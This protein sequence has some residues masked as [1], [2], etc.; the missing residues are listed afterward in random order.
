MNAFIFSKRATCCFLL[1]VSS[2]LIARASNGIAGPGWQCAVS[3][4]SFS[5][6]SSG[7][8]P[9][10]SAQAAAPAATFTPAS[11]GNFWNNGGTLAPT[12][13]TPEIQALATGLDNDPV[14]IF[15]YVHNQIAFQPYYGSNK[16]AQVTYLD[17]AGNDVDQ[18]SLLI[19]L[20]SQV[21]GCTSTLYVY[22]V[23]AMPDSPVDPSNPSDPLNNENLSNW[24]GVPSAA[25]PYVLG[26]N[27]VP[28]N[29]RGVSHGNYAVWTFDHVWVR[30]TINGQ[31]YDLDPSYKQYTNYNP[32]DFKTASGYV[33][34]TLLSNAEAGSNFS[35]DNTNYVQ[36]MS[37]ANVESQLG[38]CAFNLQNYIKGNLP[39]ANYE[40]AQILGGGHINSQPITALAQ[41][42]P[43][44]LFSPSVM[45]TFSSLPS[46][47]SSQYTSTG[48]SYNFRAAFEVNIDSGAIDETFYTDNLQGKRL[49]VTFDSGSTPQQ[50]Q[51]WWS[52]TQVVEETGGT[53]MTAGVTET[54]TDPSGFSQS[55]PLTGNPSIVYQRTGNYDLTYSFFP[56]PYSNGQI[57]E[58]TRQIQNYLASGHADSSRQVLTETLHSL[59]LKWIRRVALT[60]QMT[61]RA[62]YTVANGN[63]QYAPFAQLDHI[64]GRTGQ[65][66]GFFVDMPGVFFTY[67]DTASDSNGNSVGQ[68]GPTARNAYY[69]ALFLSSAM[70]HG[71]IEQTTNSTAL[72]AIKCLALANDQGQQIYRATQSNW[73]TG[74]NVQSKL[75]TSNGQSTYSGELST[76]G[77][78]IGTYDDIIL[79][80]QN[81]QTSVNPGQSGSQW[82]G[83]GYADFGTRTINGLQENFG[84]LIIAGNWGSSSGGYES[85]PT[86]LS[87]VGDDTTIQ[88]DT[89]V[90][91]TGTP[92]ATNSPV[93]T[94]ISSD[95]TSAEPV[96]LLTGAYTM[97]HTDLTLGEQGSPRGLNFTRYY[98]GLRNFTP[99]PLGNGWRHSCQG[100]ITL[101]SELDNAFGLTQPTDAVQTIV[102]AIVVADFVNSPTP[103]EMLVGALAANWTVNCMT[104]NAANVQIGN[105]VSTYI[106][107]PNGT[108]TWN[109]PPGS[110]TDLT[111]ASGSFALQP[112]LGG[113]IVFDSQNRISTWTDV[114]GNQEIYFYD[115]NGNLQTVTDHFGRTL[116]FSY[117]QNGSAYLLQNVVDSTGR[118]V[119]FT[120]TAGTSTGVNSPSNLTGITDPQNY[121]TTLVYDGRNR[122]TDW[123]DSSSNDITHND[124]DVLDRVSQ[125]LSQ[126]LTA[127]TWLFH[128]SP[129]MTLQIDPQGD[130]TTNLFDY[131]NRNIGTIDALENASSLSYDGQNHVVSTVDA[132]NRKTSYVYDAN[133]NLVT[134]TDNNNNTTYCYYNST[135]PF[136][137]SQVKDANGFSTFYGY[138]NS[139]D[140][141]QHH[142]TSIT[143]AGGRELQYYFKANGLLD[144]VVDSASK[145][146]SYA[147]YDA[148]GN[149]TNITRADGTKTSA[150]Y[151]ARGDLLSSTD[152]LNNTTYYS[153]DNRRLMLTR[154]DANLNTTT[155]TYDSNG[156]PAT[157]TDRNNNTTTYVYDNLGHELSAQSPATGNIF[158]TYDNRGWLT[159]VTDGLGNVTTYGYD[160]TGRRTSVTNP[161]SIT[162]SQ[163]AY[164]PAGRVHVQTDGL[165][166]E[167]V[168][169]YDTV[170]YLAS[171]TDPL[172]HIT[173]FFY[174]GT[175]RKSKLINKNNQP[176]QFGYSTTDGLP[177]TFTYPSGRQSL[178]TARDAHGL[179]M[180]L[181][182]PSGNT[183]NLTYDAMSRISTSADG[184]GGIGWTY[185]NEGNP[186]DIK[187]TL[188]NN[189]NTTDI[190]RVYDNLG[191]VTSCTDTQL[192]TVGYS[193]DNEGNLATITYPGG[194][195]VTY[196]YDG[197]NRLTTVKDWSGR[198]TKYTYDSAGRLQTVLR[199]NNTQQTVTFDAASRLTGSTEQLLNSNGN[200]TLWQAAYGYDNA[201]HLTSFAPLPA[202]QTQAP[203]AVALTYNNDNELSTY[204]GTNVNYDLDGN[205]LSAPLQ[206]TSL[207]ALM[208]DARNRLTSA[209]GVTYAYDAENRRISSTINVNGQPQTTT[210]VW[211]RGAKLDQLLEKINPDL[212]VTHYIYGRGLLYEV[213]SVGGVDENP[214]YYHFDWRGDTVALSDAYGNVTA[215]LSYSPY[216]E[217]T[218]ESG[219]V[220]T[221][222]L[223]NGKW[224]VLTESSGLLAMQARFYSPIIQRF[225]NEDPSGFNGG[226]NMY[227]YAGGDP[228]N[229][230][231]PFGLR[232]VNADSGG[233]LTIG[234]TISAAASGLY[235]LTIGA[236]VSGYNAGVNHLAAAIS[237]AQQGDFVMAALD[238]TATAGDIAG[239]ALNVSGAGAVEEEGVNL[240]KSEVTQTADTAV[241]NAA[242]TTAVPRAFWVGPEGE[243]A[244][245]QS[246]AQLLQP[247]QAALDAAKAGDWSVMRAESAEWA[248]GASG[249]VP[250]FFGNGK[251]RIFLNDELPQLLKGMDAGKVK[252]IDITF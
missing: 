199:P 194:K 243:L 205:M 159:N 133:Q 26:D 168:L 234:Q 157:V 222:L 25:T 100:L 77:G 101:S 28:V 7:Q 61:G 96:D 184:V 76:I 62:Q 53:G 148:Y 97:Q 22:G 175:G 23:Y 249:D 18:A 219:T 145:T 207:G 95:P 176:F 29:H 110:T 21:P 109:P 78:D 165:G 131:K 225:L 236:A 200:V 138:D 112:R 189:N 226:T 188:A 80:H 172:N 119:Q 54:I 32:I 217:C 244:A 37:R 229:L 85:S 58:S 42:A 36:N 120:Y 149:C 72:S 198:V 16:G 140:T 71:V 128:Y 228:V 161:L 246:G 216:G 35:T 252:S 39:Y 134:T 44:S 169:N 164:D 232:P 38:A 63:P 93:A 51:L 17:G 129:G 132:T 192:N 113:S 79:M 81:G 125:Q 1:L 31:T 3:P 102:G 4:Q 12:T 69:A 208:W 5:V 40:I 46:S 237:S 48:S 143:D 251:G 99:S 94:P 121:P 9:D 247:S 173:E 238:A 152:G 215:R 92:V 181:K 211:S 163:T 114:D 49:S 223:F 154:K 104:N 108:G 126:G 64:F 224:G 242:E 117:A 115:G 231:D 65:E 193:Y 60:A 248:K 239:L 136:R 167:T 191:R 156:N 158:Y 213:T 204:N 41:G 82:M 197:S 59:G 10:N 150:T 127:D 214:I 195:T 218:I 185:D 34:S 8:T 124:Y 203:P 142:L 171:S 43:P 220:N 179:P 212:S 70:E 151:N 89:P 182:S 180:T 241:T 103:Q 123:K 174:D 177:T 170:G 45:T 57:D 56:N 74:F 86:T 19:A 186:T 11:S 20:L 116:T 196:F 209:G 146:T 105:D 245:Q 135:S 90:A 98:D 111:G 206:G 233:G 122:L 66:A 67:F 84:G 178:I 221:P 160:L 2:N 52:D 30:A 139:D 83:N 235:N 202:Q 27:G 118:W 147:A 153:Y 24:L 6:S 47:I 137:L 210:Y 190:H 75:T 68:L 201:D 187:E 33:R 88:T 14:K 250:V 230:T 13:V 15:N 240:V 183:T 166:Y 107:Q 73:S 162:T 227:A 87:G 144:Y 50:A 106:R 141:Y 130:E 91:V 155:R 55:L